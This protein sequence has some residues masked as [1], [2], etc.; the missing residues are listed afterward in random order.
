MEFEDTIDRRAAG[1]DDSRDQ[2]DINNSYSTND[3][4]NAVSEDD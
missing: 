3:D 1:F 2:Q 4:V